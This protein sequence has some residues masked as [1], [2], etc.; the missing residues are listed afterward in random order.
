[1][2]A[3]SPRYTPPAGMTLKSPFNWTPPADN[4][5]LIGREW[6]Y[7]DVYDCVIKPPMTSTGAVRAV[8][9]GGQ[10]GTGKTTIFNQIVV[11]SPFF[12]ECAGNVNH[13]SQTSLN[14]SEQRVLTLTCSSHTRRRLATMSVVTRRRVPPVPHGLGAELFAARLRVPRGGAVGQQSVARRVR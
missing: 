4:G 6:L 1:M 7:R 3:K 13:V 10:G 5:Q 11:N 8:L 9:V 14:Q 2:S 12:V